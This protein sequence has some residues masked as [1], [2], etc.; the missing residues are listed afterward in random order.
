MLCYGFLPGY[1]ADEVLEALQRS[2]TLNGL[3]VCVMS[4]ES[5]VL[6]LTTLATKLQSDPSISANKWASDVK[7]ELERSGE[8]LEE[9]LSLGG[10]YFNF[11]VLAR[12]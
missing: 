4:K 12:E 9:L 11:L 5:Y 8:A 1:F 7:E 2:K 10:N 3:G 6:T